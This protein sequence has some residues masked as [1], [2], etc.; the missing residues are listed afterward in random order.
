MV[1]CPSCE[2]DDFTSE[3]GVKIHHKKAHGQSIAQTEECVWCGSDFR[4]SHSEQKYCSEGC[5]GEWLSENKSGEDHP[6]WGGRIEG[7]CETC[8][9]MFTFRPSAS[10]RRFCGRDCFHA[11]HGS[12]WVGEDHPNWK[13]GYGKWYGKSWSEQ[14]QKAIERDGNSCRVCGDSPSED[15]SIHVHHITPFREFGLEKHEEANRLENLVTLCME[16]H[17]QVEQGEIPCPEN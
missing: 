11:W 4:P 6:Q 16:H 15:Y 12:V 2:R 8:G 13:G 3:H 14:R 10:D 7:E 17:I 1:D 5:Y 9:D